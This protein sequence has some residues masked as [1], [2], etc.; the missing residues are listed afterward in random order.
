VAFFL[1]TLPVSAPLQEHEKMFRV[2]IIEPAEFTFLRPLGE[3]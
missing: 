3:F 1:V 2:F